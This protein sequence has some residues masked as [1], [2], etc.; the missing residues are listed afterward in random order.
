MFFHYL[1][2][3]AWHPPSCGKPLEASEEFLG[4]HIC[5]N[6]EVYCLSDAAGEEA[7][8]H[9]VVSPKEWM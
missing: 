3:I 8:P 2:R 9:F 5:H 6:V 7:N 4:K 1:L